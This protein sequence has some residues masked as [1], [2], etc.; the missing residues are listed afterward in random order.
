MRRTPDQGSSATP[1]AAAMA[2]L[3]GLPGGACPRPLTETD[4]DA[5]AG[6]AR[7][8][9]APADPSYWRARLRTHGR[10]CPCCY[11]VEIEGQLVA[12][13]LGQAR[14]GDFGL[15]DEVAWLEALGVH[16][17]WQGQGFARALA[18][19]LFAG[20]ASRG[21]SRVLT[22]VSTR[23]DRLHAFFRALGFGQSRLTCLERRL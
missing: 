7:Q 21:V 5:L 22:V 3:S 12:H 18:E 15:P 2:Q 19:A 8:L 1:E 17:A 20:C 10:D 13:V 14:Q 6:A 11:G 16:P 23:D 9:G 4:A